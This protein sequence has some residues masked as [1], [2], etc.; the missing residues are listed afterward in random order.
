MRFVGSPVGGGDSKQL[1]VGG[2]DLSTI[3]AAP[4]AAWDDA[5]TVVVIGKQD[6]PGGSILLEEKNQG[7]PAGKGI[8]K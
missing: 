5:V 3:D 1:P 2:G 4:F 8:L 7:L 6:T